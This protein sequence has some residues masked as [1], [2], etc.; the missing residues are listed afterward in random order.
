MAKESTKV[1]PYFYLGLLYENG[2]G[3][4]QDHTTALRYYKKAANMGF[5]KAYTKC[6][7]LLYSGKGCGKKDKSEAFKCYQRAA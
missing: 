5:A 4:D 2:L 6:G 7:D 3:V 1:E